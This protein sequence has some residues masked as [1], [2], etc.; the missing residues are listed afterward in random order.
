MIRIKSGVYGFRD[1]HG[2]LQPKTSK[3]KEFSL[4]GEEEE[5]LVKRGV[6]VYVESD[7]TPGA[8]TPI[9]PVATT[10]NGGAGT[11]E[12]DNPPGGENAANGQDDDDNL[13]DETPVYNLDMTASQLKELMQEYGI[14]IKS[15]MNKTEMMA[16]LDAYFA[17]GDDGDGE[18]PGLGAADPVV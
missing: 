18:P 5:R 15:G 14:T 10:A 13:D 8:E 9:A 17:D 7:S 2:N 12:G 16:A 1:E 4:S 6:A 11:G 3:S